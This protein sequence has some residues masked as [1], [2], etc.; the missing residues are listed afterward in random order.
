MISTILQAFGIA[1]VATGLALM[2]LPLGIVSAG[3][4]VLLFGIAL[5]KGK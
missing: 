5:E 3:V 1:V 2:Y 4:G